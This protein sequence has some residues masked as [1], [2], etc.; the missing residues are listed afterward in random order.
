ME[1]VKYPHEALSTVCTPVTEFNE[2]LH[3]ILDAM[4]PVMEQAHGIGLAAN[5]VGITKRFFL[6][7][8]KKGKVWEFINPEIIAHDGG[9]QINEGCLSAPGVFVQVPRFGSVTVKAQNRSGEE[10]QIIAEEIEA[11]CIQ[12]EIDHL[13][14]I[15]FIEKTSRNQRRAALRQ[16]G[17]K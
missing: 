16:L 5:Q 6:M 8:D 9:Q 17:L 15:F 13:Q 4:I 10:F 7:K 2:E 3:K 1:I 11:V 12:H 14:G